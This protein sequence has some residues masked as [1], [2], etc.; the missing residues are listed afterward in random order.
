MTQFDERERGFEAKFVHD[1]DI[2]FRAEAL[3]VRRIA[4]WAAALLGHVGATAETYAEGALRAHLDRPGG[5]ALIQRLA[6][7]LARHAT[8]GEIRAQLQ[9]LRQSARAELTAPVEA[10][11]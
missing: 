8:L 2:L 1:E 4:H 11:S 3:A 10:A 7:D 5:D 6:E 9:D